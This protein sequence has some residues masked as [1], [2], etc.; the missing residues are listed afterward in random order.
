MFYSTKKN[1][2]SHVSG[3]YP[4]VMRIWWTFI[5]IET[6]ALRELFIHTIYDTYDNKL[7]SWVLSKF[8]VTLFYINYVVRLNWHIKKK[9]RSSKNY[10]ILL[11]ETFLSFL[12]VSV[13]W[14]LQLISKW[15]IY[16]FIKMVHELYFW[17]LFL[18]GSLFNSS[19]LKWLWHFSTSC[20]YTRVR[21]RK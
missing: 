21:V 15:A 2:F 18:F 20:M 17:F 3:W 10:L 5:E 7:F 11:Y 1:I 6:K 4:S 14:F 16:K 12:L 19:G 13:I 9:K 8:V